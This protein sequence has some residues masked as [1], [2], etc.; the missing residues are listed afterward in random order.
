MWFLH[1]IYKGKIGGDEQ[2]WS[3]IELY[4]GHQKY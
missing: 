3:L 1:E 2:L 4:S